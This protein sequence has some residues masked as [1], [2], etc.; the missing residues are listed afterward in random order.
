MMLSVQQQEL[1]RQEEHFSMT[2][3]VQQQELERQEEQHLCD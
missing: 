1:Q 3:S 2:L